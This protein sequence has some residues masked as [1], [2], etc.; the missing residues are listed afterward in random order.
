[1]TTMR[2]EVADDALE[3][4][5]R[6]SQ[7][8]ALAPELIASRTLREALAVLPVGGGRAVVVSG[9][10]LERLGE[11]LAGGAVLNQ[12]DLVKKVERLAGV[13]FLHARLPFTPT[14]LEELAARA[15]RQGLT[16]QQLVDRAA[17]RIYDTFFN[18]IAV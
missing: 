3:V 17:P 11:I 16:V 5:D 13:S 8:S 7:R 1:V 12:D 4:L 10:A 15:A 2:I 6:A 9:A 18:M 14:Q